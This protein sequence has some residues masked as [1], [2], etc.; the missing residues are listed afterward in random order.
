MIVAAKRIKIIGLSNCL[1]KRRT[2]ELPDFT[3]IEFGPLVANLLAASAVLNPP[4]EITTTGYS[5]EKV[6][7]LVQ[8]G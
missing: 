8:P 4:D 5:R 7:T 3:S 6:K 1:R 2:I